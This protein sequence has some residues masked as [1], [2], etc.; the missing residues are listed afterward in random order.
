MLQTKTKQKTN[1]QTNRTGAN[2][3]SFIK[4]NILQTQFL[5]L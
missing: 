3:Q 1:K 5:K 2:S 4:K